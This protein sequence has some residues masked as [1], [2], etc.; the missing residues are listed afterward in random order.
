MSI[1][2]I[3]C[4]PRLLISHGETIQIEDITNKIYVLGKNEPYPQN[5]TILGEIKT[6]GNFFTSDRFRVNQSIELIK[7]GA[8][9]LNANA[10]KIEE[11]RFPGP[12]NSKSYDITALGLHIEQ[13]TKQRFDLVSE[14]DN[15]NNRHIK[16][17]RPNILFGS[18][19]SYPIYINNAFVCGL[20]N[21][22]RITIE[23][24]DEIE[25][26]YLQIESYGNLYKVPLFF[27]N[28]S[29]IHI[30]CLVGIDGSPQVIMPEYNIGEKEYSKVKNTP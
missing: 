27:N 21:D 30:K 4:S 15:K 3:S 17:Y 20:D 2:Q 19:I 24:L 5:S 13:E 16:L 25:E 14:I 22:S 23:L 11:I 29:V 8:I 28:S 9:Q 26:F 1:I 12:F 7:K 10:V 18:G 6:K